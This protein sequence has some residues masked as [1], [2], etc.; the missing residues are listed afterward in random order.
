MN[1]YR[2]T[3]VKVGLAFLAGGILGAG[4]ALLYAPQSGKKTRREIQKTAKKLKNAG[5]E[6]VDEAIHKVADV[7]GD[8]K[9][10]AEELIYQGRDLTDDIKNEL[11]SRLDSVQK[12]IEKQ[13]KRLAP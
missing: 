3:S 1:S 12:V 10:R 4:I 5:Y 7:V 8:V 6:I 11:V 2:D 9:D 13:K